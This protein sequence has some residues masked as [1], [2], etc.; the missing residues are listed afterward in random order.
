MKFY[1][2]NNREGFAID[3]KMDAKE[4]DFNKNLCKWQM[5]SGPSGTFLQIFD[6]QQDIDSSKANEEIFDNWYFDMGTPIPN[7]PGNEGAPVYPLDGQ[8]LGFHLC[9][10]VLNNQVN[11]HIFIKSLNISHCSNLEKVLNE[12]DTPQIQQVPISLHTSGAK[13]VNI[14]K[15]C[16]YPREKI[17][18]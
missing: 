2:C 11:C 17:A 3:G 7:V 16:R 15:I 5:A 18:N 12:N 10:K 6:F 9:S 8:P 4:I 13:I 14:R 1:N